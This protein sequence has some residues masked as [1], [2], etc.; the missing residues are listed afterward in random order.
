[1]GLYSQN[2]HIL[3]TIILS[4][5]AHQTGKFTLLLAEHLHLRLILLCKYRQLVEEVEVMEEIVVMVA[6]LAAVVEKIALKK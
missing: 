6:V 4:T 1:M 5:K 2:L 3:V